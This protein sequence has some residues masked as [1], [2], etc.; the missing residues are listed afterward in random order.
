MASEEESRRKNIVSDEAVA[1]LLGLDKHSR[2]MP[3]VLDAEDG[4]M[5]VTIQASKQ[6]EFRKSVNARRKKEAERREKNEAERKAR[7]F[8]AEIEKAEVEAKLHEIGQRREAEEV[9]AK[10]RAEHERLYG[11]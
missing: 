3:E 6:V 8:Q 7:M 9:A 11:S 2:P 10:E 5:N 4:S 1:R